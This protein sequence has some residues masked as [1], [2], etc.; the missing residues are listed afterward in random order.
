M[1]TKMWPSEDAARECAHGHRV[2]GKK[3]ICERE[4]RIVR[5]T[6]QAA[7]EP[8]EL[9]LGDVGVSKVE[10]DGLPANDPAEHGRRDGALPAQVDPTPQTLVATPASPRQPHGPALLMTVGARWKTAVIPKQRGR[11][12]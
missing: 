12:K 9:L 7:D 2:V 4:G 3:C 11:R 8:D 10:R 5:Q 6:W 1:R